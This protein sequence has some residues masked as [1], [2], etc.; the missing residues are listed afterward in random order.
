MAVLSARGWRWEEGKRTEQNS[1][2]AKIDV[3]DSCAGGESITDALVCDAS[4]TSELLRKE[5]MLFYPSSVG[6]P[7]FVKYLLSPYQK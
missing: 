6:R 7:S 1:R 4:G 5:N 2:N 3:L